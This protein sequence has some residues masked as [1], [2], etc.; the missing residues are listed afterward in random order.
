LQ[1]IGAGGSQE[2]SKVMTLEGHIVAIRELSAPRG[3]N[4]LLH[5][6]VTVTIPP[7]DHTLAA[8][9]IVGEPAGRN[10]ALK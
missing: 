5:Q 4:I 8:R 1:N 6:T 2:V 3:S 9:A 7:S 10:V